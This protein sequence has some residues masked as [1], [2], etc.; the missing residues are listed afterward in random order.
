MIHRSRSNACVAHK[1]TVNV[2]VQLI[3]GKTGRGSEARRA[4]ASSIKADTYHHNPA[5]DYTVFLW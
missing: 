1:A 4:Y 2:Q 5:S 3:S